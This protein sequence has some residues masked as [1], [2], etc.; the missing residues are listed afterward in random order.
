MELIIIMSMICFCLYSFT[1]VQRLERV[2]VF[3]Q[4]LRYA[5]SILY[6]FGVFFVVVALP[7]FPDAVCIILRK[8]HADSLS[9]TRWKEGEVLTV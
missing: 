5:C 1:K 3:L 9:M 8:K 4:S 7:S 2:L 6:F